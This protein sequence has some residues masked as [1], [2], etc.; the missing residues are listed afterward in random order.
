MV[1]VWMVWV[2]SL[3]KM[4]TDTKANFIMVSSMGKANSPGQM[5]F[6]IKVNSQTTV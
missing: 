1:N 5:A 4:A 6:N 2:K 3:S